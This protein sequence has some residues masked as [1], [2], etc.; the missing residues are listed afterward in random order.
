MEDTFAPFFQTDLPIDIM[1]ITK[2]IMADD[3]IQPAQTLI[4][5]V[6]S[7]AI[8]ELYIIGPILFLLKYDLLRVA[9]Y[10]AID[11]NVNGWYTGAGMTYLYNND[12][13]QFADHFWETVNRYRP[14]ITYYATRKRWRS[15]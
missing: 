5:H 15:C 9:N 1:R 7:A 6:R 10:E 4:K 3:S 2:E 11:A 13:Q 12:I 14:G 8:H